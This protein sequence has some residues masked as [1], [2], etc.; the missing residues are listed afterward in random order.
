MAFVRKSAA[1]LLPLTVLAAGLAAIDRFDG[2][3]GLDNVGR[4]EAGIV[5]FAL[6][7]VVGWAAAHAADPLRSVRR[8][9]RDEGLSDPELG[10]R[11]RELLRER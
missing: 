7:A 5:V 9:V 2:L 1:V 3:I 6:A 10:R 11:I 8:L 4:V